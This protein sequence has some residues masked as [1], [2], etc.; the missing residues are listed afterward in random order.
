MKTCT[1]CSRELPLTKQYFS[2]RE[3][4]KDGFRNQCKECRRLGRKEWIEKTDYNWGRDNPEKKNQ[5]KRSFWAKHKDRLN[6]E[7][8]EDR[9]KNPDKYRNLSLVRLYGITLDKYIQMHEEQGG[10]C[11]ICKKPETA[12]RKDGSIRW[13]CVD[14]N[15]TTKENRQLLCSRCNTAIGLIF[16]NI[17]ISEEVT[18][19][20]RRHS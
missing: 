14:H 19:Y 10:L 9:A 5:L 20:L 8:K 4:A 15:H 11:A 7:R 18:K 3:L 12:K 1:K 17:K 13:L 16:D 2:P 6:F